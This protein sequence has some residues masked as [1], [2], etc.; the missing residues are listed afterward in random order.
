MSLEELS[1]HGIDVTPFARLSVDAQITATVSLPLLSWAGGR[2]LPDHHGLV[3]S[4][5]L[6]GLDKN[7]TPAVYDAFHREKEGIEAATDR[8]CV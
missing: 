4:T 5:A 1:S 3:G 2:P 8:S 6:A 7:P